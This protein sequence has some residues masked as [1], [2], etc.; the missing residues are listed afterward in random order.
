LFIA[1]VLWSMLLLISSLLGMF[2]TMWFAS[3]IIGIS[4]LHLLS[5]KLEI[6]AFIILFIL[7]AENIYIIYNIFFA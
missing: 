6:I 1:D 5:K 4:N 2:V 7:F 3:L